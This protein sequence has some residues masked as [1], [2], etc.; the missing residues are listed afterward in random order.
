[1]GLSSTTVNLELMLRLSFCSAHMLWSNSLLF[2]T[3][4]NDQIP[5]LVA[6][7]TPV[8]L[9][10]LTPSGTD[11]GLTALEECWCLHC[12]HRI[13][14]PSAPQK[15]PVLLL[16]VAAGGGGWLLWLA[17]NP[18]NESLHSKKA[19]ELYSAASTL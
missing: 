1:M 16:G 13:F 15:P 7:V 17:G 6:K 12:L 9:L 5:L 14:G 19:T 3:Y 8:Q 18:V 11:W 10:K 4:P 2:G